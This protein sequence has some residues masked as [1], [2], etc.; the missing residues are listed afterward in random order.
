MRASRGWRGATG[1][2]AAIFGWTD[3]PPTAM[4]R[5]GELARRAVESDDQDSAAH[6]SL[7]IHDLF[8]SKEADQR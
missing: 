5:M 4:T 3:S 8:S 7:A 6:T 1:H 2:F